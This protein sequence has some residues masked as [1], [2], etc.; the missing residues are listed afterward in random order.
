MRT[1]GDFVDRF[2][3]ALDR[4]HRAR[5]PRIGV[6]ATAGD[7]RDQDMVEL[8]DRSPPSTSTSV[9]V[10]EDDA[11][12]RAASAGETAGADRRGRRARRRPRAPACKQVE[13]VLD[14]IDADR[15]AM[16]RRQR[17]RPGGALRRP[18]RPR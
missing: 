11:A 9:I 14:E 8:G 16:A 17:R 4:D 12:A 6:V 10:R 2:F 1:L 3:E 7:R 15:H 5:P 18:A 13:V